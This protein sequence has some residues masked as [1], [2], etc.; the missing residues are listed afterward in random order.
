MHPRLLIAQATVEGRRPFDGASEVRTGRLVRI[1]GAK[2]RELIQWR[3]PME[4]M[5]CPTLHQ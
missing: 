5:P 2:A 4:P 3:V 1:D